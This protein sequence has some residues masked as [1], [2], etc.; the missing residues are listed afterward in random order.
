MFSFCYITQMKHGSGKAVK[1]HLFLARWHQQPSVNFPV[2]NLVKM[3]KRFLN[4]CVYKLQLN[5]S[6]KSFS[7]HFIFSPKCFLPLGS[8]RQ[9]LIPL[10]TT[11]NTSLQICSFIF[12][13]FGAVI[14]SSIMF[15]KRGSMLINVLANESYWNHGCHL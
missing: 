1:S 3:F 9:C 14:L 12:L 5:T 11:F 7:N 6:L 10:L 4:I 13:H 15:P 8:C 2:I